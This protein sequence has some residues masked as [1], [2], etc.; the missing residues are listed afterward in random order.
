ML[1]RARQS[2]LASRVVAWKL[3]PGGVDLEI[4]SPGDQSAARQE[5][6]LEP[7]R[8]V[9]LFVANQGTESSFKDFATVRR[10]LAE[11]ARTGPDRRLV[12]LAVGVAGRDEHFGSGIV[13][14]RIGYIRSPRLLASFYRAADIYVHAALEET[15]G[16][17]VAEALACATPVI[18]ASSGGVLEIVEH[19]HT[20]LVVPPRDHVGL[21]ASIARLLG[22]ASLR[23]SLGAAAAASARALLGE[24]AMIA[25]LHA[26]CSQIHASWTPG[27]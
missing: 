12:L 8:S 13:V 17:S 3:I 2:L 26:W 23:A 10:A 9:L 6:G 15:F 11:L 21:A 22:D 7:D 18:A 4:F 27:A 16:L 20:A 25:A 5:L 19:G 14:R 1:E 24:R